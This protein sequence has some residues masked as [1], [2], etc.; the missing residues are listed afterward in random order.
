MVR[1]GPQGVRLVDAVNIS[2]SDPASTRPSTGVPRWPARVALLVIGG[3]FLFISDQLT[4]GPSWLPLAVVVSLLVLG[5][6]AIRRERHDI[7]RVIALTTVSIIT[8]AVVIST[9][10]LVSQLFGGG[11]AAESM[12]QGSGL[13]WLA[14]IVTFS[15]WYWEIDGG[16]PAKRRMDGH[17]TTDFL[18]PQLQVGEGKEIHGWSPT[19]LDYAFVAWNASTAFSPTDTLIMSRR[20]KVLMM[21]QSLTSLVT[22][23]VLAARAINTLR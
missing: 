12:L 7:G 15:V 13:I 17:I 21:I 10:Y 11:L 20:A 23:A 5:A 22:I 9:T 19:F 4:P 6:L 3:L 16:G 8:V 18:F 14:N 2:T 1:G